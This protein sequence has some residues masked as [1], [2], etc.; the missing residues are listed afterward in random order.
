MTDTRIVAFRATADD[1][2][3]RLDAVLGAHPDVESRAEA[4]RLID[5]GAVTVNGTVK[6]KRHSL[7]PGDEVR[8]DLGPLP[9]PP[10]EITAEHLAVPIVFADEHLLV[11]DKPAGMVTHPSRG[12]SAGT[13]VHGLI[14]GG[15]AGGDDPDRPGIVHRLDRDTSGLLLVARTDTAHR[16][17]GRMM[18]D[19]EIDRRYLALAYGDFPPALTVDR[20]VGRD[21][22]RRT[23]QAV[24]PVGGREAVT[25]FRRLEVI[26]PLALVEA[27]LET[28]RTHQVRVHLESAGHPVFGD[29]VYGRGRPDHDLGRQ[30]LH[31]Y[32]LSFTH[33]F[34]GREMAFESPLP[35]DLEAALRA[36]RCRAG[37][38]G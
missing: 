26:G 11:V 16:R 35:D 24:V 9:P 38:A 6:P 32:K 36:A 27:R 37:A 28:G 23:R 21:P 20:P 30:F 12:H 34:G 10:G 29:P 13:L 19:R 18:R 3:R 8:A 25:H 7:T 2:G 14:G 15:I 5:A 17:L 33:P 4:Q 22:R 31:A 1:A